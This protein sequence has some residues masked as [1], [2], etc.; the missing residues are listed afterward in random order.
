MKSGIRNLWDLAFGCRPAY[1][2]RDA[3]SDILVIYFVLHLV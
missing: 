1:P 2:H 3:P